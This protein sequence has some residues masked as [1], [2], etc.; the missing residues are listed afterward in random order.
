M[1]QKL[2]YRGVT[3][4]VNP[5]N[6]TVLF[7]SVRNPPFLTDRILKGIDLYVRK[8]G[9]FN[10]FYAIRWDLSQENSNTYHILTHKQAAA[11]MASLREDEEFMGI[12]NEVEGL[13]K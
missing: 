2:D 6:D 7:K 5:D 13:F 8:T 12:I 11:L 10:F 4:S 1:I 3:I 9:K